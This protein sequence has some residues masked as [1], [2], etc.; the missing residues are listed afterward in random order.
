M[1]LHSRHDK[2]KVLQILFP[3][4]KE[5]ERQSSAGAP[6]RFMRRCPVAVWLRLWACS[7]GKPCSNKSSRSV[8][9]QRDT[10]ESDGRPFWRKLCM[11]WRRFDTQIKHRSRYSGL[12][13]KKKKRVFFFALSQHNL[14]LLHGYARC[15]S[16]I[17]HMNIW[18]EASC[19]AVGLT[20]DW[21]Q[22]GT[23]PNCTQSH[24]SL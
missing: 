24:P 2:V 21:K 20:G 22:W 15:D 16:T 14:C 17:T 9:C 6:P 10:G 3:H 18:H 1:N 5:T 13:T 4:S 19:V 8:R 11:L 23:N 7:C 12:Q